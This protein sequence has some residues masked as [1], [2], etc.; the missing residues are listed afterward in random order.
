MALSSR[1]A[2]DT[3]AIVGG[4]FLVV[5]AMSFSATPAHWLAFGV[6]TAFTIAAAAGAAVAR[7]T[8]QQLAH[9]ALALVALWSLITPLVFTG[10]TQHWL[11]FANAIG[12]AVVAL[13]DLIAHES[14]TERVVH[15]LHV[16]NSGTSRIESP[17][18]SDE[19]IG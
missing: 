15:E 17:E 8:H 11:I 3:T 9:G 18:R 14:T 10:T 1:F 7:R 16:R 13:G 12:L 4:A 5:S 2:L 6:S 19:L